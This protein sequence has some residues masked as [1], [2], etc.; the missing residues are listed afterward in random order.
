M[1]LSSFHLSPSTSRSGKDADRSPDRASNG[2]PGR[3]RTPVA[4]RLGAVVGVVFVALLLATGP[5]PDAVADQSFSTYFSAGALGGLALLGGSFAAESARARSLRRHGTPPQGIS[6]GAFG[7]QLVGATP[8]DNPRTLRRFAWS[9][10]I[11]LLACGVVAAAVAVGFATGSGSASTLLAVTAGWVGGLL[12][13]FALVEL[14]PRPGAP[15]GQ[16]IAARAWRRT[17]DRSAGELATARAGIRAGWSVGVVAALGTLLLSPLA[18]WLL[19]VAFITV[20]SSKAA[21]AGATLRRQVSTISVRDVMSPAPPS[22]L[23]WS[24]VESALGQLPAFGPRPPALMV[25]DVDGVWAGVAP[26]PVLLAVPGDDRDTARVRQIMVARDLVATVPPTATVEEALDRLT[27]RPAAGLVL[28]LDGE[29]L[30]GVLSAFDIA[31]LGGVQL[32]QMP[33]LPQTPQWPQPGSGQ[34]PQ[35]GRPTSL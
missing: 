25:S 24:T 9:G 8:P 26:L 2:E 30:V 21:L 22:T 20:M 33:Q 34:G 14:L 1:G 16:L 18:I 12:G 28:V 17:G 19:P 3:G 32:P 15:G 4:A 35:D 5:L 23:A 6:L 27:A 11:A 13:L 31:R 10:P 29:E 7:G